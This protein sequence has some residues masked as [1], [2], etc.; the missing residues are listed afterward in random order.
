MTS[1]DVLTEI[2][3]ALPRV[4]E[5]T[6]NIIMDIELKTADDIG[7]RLFIISSLIRRIN[8][9]QKAVLEALNILA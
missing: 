3:N 1:I 5:D 7:L 9:P 4:N 6:A 8:V 2:R